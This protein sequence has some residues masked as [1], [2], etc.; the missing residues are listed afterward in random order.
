MEGGAEKSG[1]LGFIVNASSG[2]AHDEQS[3]DKKKKEIKWIEITTSDV[4]DQNHKKIS[5]S[6]KIKIEF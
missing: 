2:H 5:N 6:K 3:A 1:N 4:F